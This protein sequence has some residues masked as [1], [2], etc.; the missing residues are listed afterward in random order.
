MSPNDFT[1]DPSVIELAAEHRRFSD[2]EVGQRVGLSMNQ[3]APG[4]RRQSHRRA[5]CYGWHDQR[6]NWHRSY[7][8]EN[9]ELDDDSQ[10]RLRFACINELSIRE[11]DRK[12]H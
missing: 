1:Q 6:D 5:I 2:A 3:R 7:G 12:S 9:W 4:I 8:N 10:M 11:S